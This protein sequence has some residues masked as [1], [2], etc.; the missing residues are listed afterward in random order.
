VAK[1]YRAS[2]RRDTVTKISWRFSALVPFGFVA[3]SFV[4]GD[5]DDVR[6]H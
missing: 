2:R 3:V 4:D 6:G 5:G 1:K